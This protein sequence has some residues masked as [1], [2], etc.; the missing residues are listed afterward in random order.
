MKWL[1]LKTINCV[2]MDVPLFVASDLSSLIC[3]Y[4]SV[5]H[6]NAAWWRDFVILIVAHS[7]LDGFQRYSGRHNCRQQTNQSGCLDERVSLVTISKRLIYTTFSWHGF[8]INTTHRTCITK[9]TRI[10]MAEEAEK[11]KHGKPYL[12][13]VDNFARCRGWGLFLAKRRMHRKCFNFRFFWIGF[14]TNT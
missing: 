10:K 4:D 7:D 1:L 11:N 9:S 12:T 5:M 2:P 13:S 14:Y 6:F 3:L 8:D